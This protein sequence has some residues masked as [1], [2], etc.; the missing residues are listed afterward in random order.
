MSEQNPPNQWGQ[1]QQPPYGQQPGQPPYGQPPYGGQGY[2]GQPP[3]GGSQ[4]PTGGGGPG[5]AIFVALAVLAVVVI[6]VVIGVV[7]TSGDDSD[8]DVAGEEESSQAV[9]TPTDEPTVLATPTEV[10]ED[11]TPTEL[12][13]PTEA[14]TPTDTATQSEQPMRV[15]FTFPERLRGYTL[16][17]SDDQWQTEASSTE[18]RSTAY[19]EKGYDFLMFF[20]TPDDDIE[21]F[22]T[23]QGTDKVHESRPID[24][25]YCYPTTSGGQYCAVGFEGGTLAVSSNEEFTTVKQLVALLEEFQAGVGPGHN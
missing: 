11:P 25:G 20:F 15:L 4:P 24:G 14:P 19:F 1:P 21:N 3:Y 9:E 10:P 5:K 23:Y 7:A 8:D 16:N 2:G 22:K 6:A 12:P 17:K 18:Y 13:T